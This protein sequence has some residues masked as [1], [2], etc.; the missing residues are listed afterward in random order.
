MATDY[1]GFIATVEREADVPHDQAERAVTATLE[2]LGERISGGEAH[3]LAGQLPPELQRLVD[4]HA[5]DG[6]RPLSAGEFFQHVQSRERVPIMEA[7][8]HV[9]AVFVALRQTVDPEEIADLASELPRELELLLFDDLPLEGVADSSPSS[10]QDFVAR[11]GRRT[12]LD[13]VGARRV[14][15]AVLEL[16]AF[17]LSAGETDD[18][19]QRLPPELRAPLERGK[20]GKPSPSAHWLPLK[21]WLIAIAE[22]E[23]VSR[24]EARLHVRAVFETLSEAIGDDE[25]EDVTAQLP[26]EFRALLPRRR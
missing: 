17:R 6:P 1:A 13:E 18:L 10:A 5:G 16:L 4:R 20:A 21:Q 11:V 12:A 7:R 8:D 23:G 19:E 22:R 14:T 15:D 24:A 9:R 3:D 25:L 2:T 26:A